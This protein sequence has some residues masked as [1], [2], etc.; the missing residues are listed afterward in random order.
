MWGRLTDAAGSRNLPERRFRPLSL[1]GSARAE[2]S[3][4]GLRR[5]LDAG[6]SLYLRFCSR[7]A[8]RREQR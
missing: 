6:F 5:G 1:V 7:I 4:N 2:S 3:A 8:G